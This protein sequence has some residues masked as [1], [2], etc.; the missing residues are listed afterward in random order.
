MINECIKTTHVSEGT[1]RSALGIRM[2]VAWIKPIQRYYD[3]QFNI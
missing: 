1:S 3:F 2:D